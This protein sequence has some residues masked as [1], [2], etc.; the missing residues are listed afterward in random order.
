[1]S[2]MM[3]EKK[4]PLIQEMTIHTND[5]N[6][7]VWKAE[8]ALVQKQFRT[9]FLLSHHAWIK[10]NHHND[11][12]HSILLYN[13]PIHHLWID[14]NQ[15]KPS[16]SSPIRIQ[17]TTNQNVSSRFFNV[18][19]QSFHHLWKKKKNR[20]WIIPLWNEII[21][22][23]TTT[24]TTTIMLSCD[25][26]LIGLQFHSSMNQDISNYHLTDTI[27]CTISIIC[28]IVSSSTTCILRRQ[29]MDLFHFLFLDL[30][31]YTTT[32]SNGICNKDLLESIFCS[33]LEQSIP[34]SSSSLLDHESTPKKEIQTWI[35]KSTNM[36]LQK[37]PNLQSLLQLQ[38]YFLSN[39]N[40]LYKI[41]T[42]KYNEDNTIM[43]IIVQECIPSCQNEISYLLSQ[44]NTNKKL[45]LTTENNN[46]DSMKHCDCPNDTITTFHDTTTTMTGRIKM[47]INY[48][49]I[50]LLDLIKE[51]KHNPRKHRQ[52]YAYCAAMIL[53]QYILWKK[54][55]WIWNKFWNVGY[56]ILITP[57][58][59]LMDATLPI[60]NQNTSNG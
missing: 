39:H 10:M 6:D 50:R 3:K 38:S 29:L 18:S 52:Y 33:I 16:S 9:A 59:D 53:S 12:N 58:K 49:V 44:M 21:F 48:W 8:Y 23:T 41:Q 5:W 51:M 26:I 30:L 36:I 54:K 35:S 24:T 46:N 28:S 57:L 55:R 40:S 56:A 17:I 1:M 11:K 19:L 34:L 42:N 60:K 4:Q 14:T 15:R 25:V 2:K 43:R 13:H 31:P 7:V 20:N 27:N 45:K 37:I 22:H 32:S 47:Y